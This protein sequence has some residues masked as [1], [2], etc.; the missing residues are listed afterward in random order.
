MEV[1]NGGALIA[2]AIAHALTLRL[3]VAEE[4]AHSHS[5]SKDVPEGVR[6]KARMVRERDNPARYQTL[7]KAVAQFVY[8]RVHVGYTFFFSNAGETN[9][10]ITGTALELGD[11]ASQVSERLWVVP[12]MP[13]TYQPPFPL[14]S[15]DWVSWR[16][17][18]QDWRKH[19]R[20]FLNRLR[21]PC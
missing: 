21:I 19:L 16:T 18:S 15:S 17:W 14:V 7:T 5:G 4:I 9:Q 13:Q 11:F 10:F 20:H 12:L 8:F 6:F 3:D 1:Q 2:A